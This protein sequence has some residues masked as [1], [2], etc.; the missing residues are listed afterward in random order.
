MTTNVFT[1]T[2]DCCGGCAGYCWEK[3]TCTNPDGKNYQRVTALLDDC[4][5]FHKQGQEDR[6]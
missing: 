6:Q 5:A 4:P 2:G 3:G 1:S